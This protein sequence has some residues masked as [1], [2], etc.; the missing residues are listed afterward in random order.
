VRQ[1]EPRRWATRCAGAVGARLSEDGAPGLCPSAESATADEGAAGQTILPRRWLLDWSGNPIPELTSASV[2]VVSLSC[3]GSADQQA[4]FTFRTLGTEQRTDMTHEIELFSLAGPI[5]LAQV[6]LATVLCSAA[7]P[8]A[9]HVD[10]T[11]GPAGTDRDADPGSTGKLG[12][13]GSVPAAS[14]LQHIAP[15]PQPA[16]NPANCLVFPA[17][18]GMLLNLNGQGPDDRI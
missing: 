4:W 1:P 12:D 18:G 9:C 2:T 15:V 5:P 17:P 16:S 14:E 7:S 11:P 3:E 13:S 10:G 8:P 6:S